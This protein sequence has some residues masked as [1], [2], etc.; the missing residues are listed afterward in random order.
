MSRDRVFQVVRVLDEDGMTSW[1]WT[2][3]PPDK[4]IEGDCL[5]GPFDTEQQAKD[6]AI[7]AL[8]G[9]TSVH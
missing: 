3:Q 2:N 1:F 4:E 8:T 7:S 6:D 5:I 9:S